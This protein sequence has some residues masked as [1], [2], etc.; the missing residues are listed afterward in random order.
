M[1]ER[2]PDSTELDPARAL[3]LIESGEA[4]LIDVRQQFEWDAGHV[5]SSTHIPL[6]Q[7]PARAPDLDRDRAL[8]FGCRSGSRSAMAAAAFRESGYDAFNLAGGL[9]AWVE[10]GLPLEPDGGEV[11]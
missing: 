6:E 4:R 7:L 3:E 11:T 5:A 1:S 10:E 8:I 9:E 2:S